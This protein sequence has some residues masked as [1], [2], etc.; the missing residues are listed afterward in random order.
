MKDTACLYILDGMSDWEPALVIAEL[1]S[2]RFFKEKG[3]NM[4]VRIVGLTKDTV[5]TM[6]G[7]ALAPSVTLDEL[8]ADEIGVLILPGATSWLEEKQAAVL[9]RPKHF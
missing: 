1:N 4:P 2:G 9:E 3:K 6:G 5:T 7:L 8:N